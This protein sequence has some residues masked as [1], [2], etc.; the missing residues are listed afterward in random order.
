M[1]SHRKKYIQTHGVS[2]HQHCKYEGSVETRLKFLFRSAR[3]RARQQDLEFNITECFIINLYEKQHGLCAMS[4]EKFL[5]AKKDSVEFGPSIDRINPKKGYT[6]KN[7]RLVRFRL[8]IMKSNLS[9]KSLLEI[10]QSI[11]ST[12]R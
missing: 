11:T 5:L 6:K 9:D 4:G 7:V 2:F 1:L 8:N 10:C 12:L 3:R